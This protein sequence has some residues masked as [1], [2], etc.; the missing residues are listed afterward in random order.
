MVAVLNLCAMTIFCWHQTA[1]VAVSAGAARLGDFAGLTD[2]PLSSGWIAERLAWFPV[3]A[4][5][6]G[7]LVALVR[8]FERPAAVVTRQHR[9]F[10]AAI[11]AAFTTYL[12][13][14]Y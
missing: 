6:L 14:V 9:M 5:A 13:M 2:P 3:L 12:L 7:L 4:V 11:V 8:R 1:L 10:A